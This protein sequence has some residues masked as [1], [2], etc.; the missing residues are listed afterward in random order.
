VHGAAFLLID[1]RLKLEEPAP[2]SE[3]VLNLMHD[4]IWSGIG[5]R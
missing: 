1:D 4:S 3:C 2:D 5:K